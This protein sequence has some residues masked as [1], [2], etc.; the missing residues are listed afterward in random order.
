MILLLTHAFP[1]QFLTH[2]LH[3]TPIL[4]VS[5]YLSCPFLRIISYYIPVTYFVK[6][7]IS[8]LIAGISFY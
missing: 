3:M 2:I 8:F 7:D 6:E 1:K 5:K 4:Y